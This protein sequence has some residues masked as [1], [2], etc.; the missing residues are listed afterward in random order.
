MFQL[1]NTEHKNQMESIAKGISKHPIK[2][3]AHA[4]HLLIERIRNDIPQKKK[5]S[6]GRYSI[7]KKLGLELF[8]LIDQ[9]QTDVLS[10]S[11]QI[12]ENFDLD[13]FVRSLAMQLISIYGLEKQN[14][15]PVLE[16]FEK[17]AGDESWELRE[18]SAGFIRKLIRKHPT[19]MKAWYFKMSKSDNAFYR[20][21]STESMR[22]VADNK[23]FLK[24]PDFC[25]SILE[26]MYQ[27]SDP[28]PRSSVGNSLS[29]WAR[30]DKE[31]VYAIIEKLVKSNNKHSYWIAYRACRNLVKKEPGRVMD[32]L[33]I[34]E[35]TYKKRNY[36]R[37]DF[38]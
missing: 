23:W 38:K 25:F 16:L 18:C 29:D 26:N 32:L 27:E 14:L 19:E 13:N 37:T 28:Y 4:L 31:R 15:K 35:Y 30:H 36:K 33:N 6:Y 22:P 20:R 24:E 10:F 11:R 1:I 8:P 2:E 9:T 5:I 21:F 34:D 3:T 17:A 7:I 12:F